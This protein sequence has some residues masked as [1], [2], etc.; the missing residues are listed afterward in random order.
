MIITMGGCLVRVSVKPDQ[1]VERKGKKA[2]GWMG[3]N[4]RDT[5]CQLWRGVLNN[6]MVGWW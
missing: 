1:L 4:R 6:E 5:G 3:E 2:R